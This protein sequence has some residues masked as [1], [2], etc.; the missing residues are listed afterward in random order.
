[1][2]FFTATETEATFRPAG[3]LGAAVRNLCSVKRE[4]TASG[5]K[6][7]KVAKIDD[8]FLYALYSSRLK[9]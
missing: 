7:I 4:A 9:L 6:N 8:N 5:N 2:Q 3:P 1:M